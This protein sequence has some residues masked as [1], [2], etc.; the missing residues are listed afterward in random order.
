[1]LHGAFNEDFPLGDRTPEEDLL[2]HVENPQKAWEALD[3]LCQSLK[4]ECR[5]YRTLLFEGLSEADLV[6]QALGPEADFAR[7]ERTK[8]KRGIGFI[9]DISNDELWGRAVLPCKEQVEEI[10]L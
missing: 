5:H 9:E 10:V 4:L 3:S 6:N 8:A 7:M 2:Y 1:M